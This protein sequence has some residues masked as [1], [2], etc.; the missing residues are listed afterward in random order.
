MNVY[1]TQLMQT[2]RE[3]ESLKLELNIAQEAWENEKFS[4]K[5]QM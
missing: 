2:K 5:E 4:L 3:L 1:L